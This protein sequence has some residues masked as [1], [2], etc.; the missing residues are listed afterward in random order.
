VKETAERSKK[1]EHESSS[2]KS[3]KTFSALCP[4]T[5]KAHKRGSSPAGVAQKEKQC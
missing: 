1:H 3:I 5:P 2:K 4:I